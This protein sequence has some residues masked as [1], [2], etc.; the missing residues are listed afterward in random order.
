MPITLGI[1]AAGALISGVSSLVAASKRNKA[2]KD[3]ENFAKTD[4][5]NQSILDFYN[6]AYNQYNPNAYQS[7]EYNAQMRNILGNQATSIGALQ[8]RRSALAG[9]PSIMQGTN[10]ASQ[11]AAA[12]A[13]AAQRANLSMLGQ[14]S[15]AKAREEQRVFGNIFNLKAQKAAAQAAAARQY[16][17]SMF[18]SL[19][20]AGTLAYK[21]KYGDD[22]KT[23][24]KDNSSSN[25]AGYEE[26]NRI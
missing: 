6:K 1:P 7:A 15:G 12:A 18:N 16:S 20:N 9:I 3:L 13:E 24:S 19:G 4:K 5:P 8:D 2:E 21:M 26:D 22:S 10:T 14:A 17:Q 11:R 23:N 25:S